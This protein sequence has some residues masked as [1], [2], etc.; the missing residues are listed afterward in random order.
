VKNL[1]QRTQSRSTDAKKAVYLSILGLFKDA[2]NKFKL[3]NINDRMYSEQE[4]VKYEKE[5]VVA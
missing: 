5:A 3:N 4:I 1:F 2:L